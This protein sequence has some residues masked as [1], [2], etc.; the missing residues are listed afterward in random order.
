VVQHCFTTPDSNLQSHHVLACLNAV[1]TETQVQAHAERRLETD[2]EMTHEKATRPLILCYFRKGRSDQLGLRDTAQQKLRGCMAASGPTPAL[3]CSRE[4]SV[5]FCRTS[6]THRSQN[7][8]PVNLHHATTSP[9]ACERTARALFSPGY[10]SPIDNPRV[11]D[12]R[13]PSLHDA[14]PSPPKRQ[15]N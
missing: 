14:D 1:P 13:R 6:V 10:R 3:R 2:P 11:F 4:R 5:S 9:S 8:N 12:E 7:S 15:N